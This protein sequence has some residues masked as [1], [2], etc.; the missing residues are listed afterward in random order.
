MI[1]DLWQIS[2][3]RRDVEWATRTM[4]KLES[5]MKPLQAIVLISVT[6]GCFLRGVGDEP[7]VRNSA[8]GEG[9]RAIARSIAVKSGVDAIQDGVIPA[10]SKSFAANVVFHG[11]VTLQN[12]QCHPAYRG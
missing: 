9:P 10:S 2:C 11:S 12:I 5:T 3:M 1:R 8:N 4:E 7:Q 6:L